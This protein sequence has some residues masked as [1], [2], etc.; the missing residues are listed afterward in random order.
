MKRVTL[1]L[2]ATLITTFLFGQNF[3]ANDVDLLL[4]K[5]IKVMEIPEILQEYGYSDF[6]INDLLKER[7]HCCKNYNTPYYSLVGKVFKI[8]SYEPYI[9]IIGSKRYKIKIE[10]PETGILYYDYHPEYRNSFAFEVIGGLD[11]PEDFYCQDIKTKTDKFEGTTISRSKDLYGIS[12]AKEIRDGSSYIYMRL[13]NEGSTL[14]VGENGLILLFE[15][16][17][18]LERPNENIDTK[19]NKHGK[20]YLYSAFIELTRPE[21]ELIIENRITDTRLFIYDAEVKYGDILSEYL[22][23]LTK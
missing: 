22:K 17:K 23:C 12:F 7:Y 18:K 11:L 4:D 10:N 2:M 14:N 13:E 21:I 16:G 19:V 6:Y 1:L 3:P 15:N 9:D 5:E 20:G 8:L